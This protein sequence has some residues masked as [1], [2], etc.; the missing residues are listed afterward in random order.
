MIRRPPRSTLFPYTTLFRSVVGGTPAYRTEM[1]RFDAPGDV[2]DFDA[3][4]ARTI[5]SPGCPMFLEARYLLAEEPELRDTAL[6]HSVLAAIAA[7]NTGRGAIAGHVGR[8]G[9]ET[10]H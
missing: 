7:G 1:I 10:P 8:K 2:A 9:H 4:A 3:W 6:Y 5:L